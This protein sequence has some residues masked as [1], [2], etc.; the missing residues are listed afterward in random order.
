MGIYELGD[1]EDT[2]AEQLLQKIIKAQGGQVHYLNGRAKVDTITVYH[3]V[4]L[5]RGEGSVVHLGTVGGVCV[6]NLVSIS[7]CRPQEVSM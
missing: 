4:M 2:A 7:P 5:M 6:N 3:S 1:S